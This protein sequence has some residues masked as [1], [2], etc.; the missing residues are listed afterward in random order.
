MMLLDGIDVAKVKRKKA[1]TPKKSRAGDST[2]ANLFDQ[3][4]M[5]KKY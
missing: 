4:F 5:W 3:C 1:W 2:V